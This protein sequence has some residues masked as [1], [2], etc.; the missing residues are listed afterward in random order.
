MSRI[1]ILGYMDSLWTPDPK[2]LDGEYPIVHLKF[3]RFHRTL[4]KR[5]GI[6]PC[7][8]KRVMF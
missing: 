7:Q 6:Y 4:L 3:C 2:D 5:P 8:S 1:K